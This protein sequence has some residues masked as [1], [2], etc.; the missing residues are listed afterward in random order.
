[1]VALRSARARIPAPPPAG[2]RPARPLSH[3]EAAALVV[4]RAVLVQ[5]ASGWES[6]WLLACGSG[7]GGRRYLVQRDAAG[8]SEPEWLAEGPV[9]LPASLPAALPA[10]QPATTAAR[11][12]GPRRP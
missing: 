5:N 11:L 2:G 10:I 9:A 1:M 6:A 3:L 7:A 8:S 12:P 4:P